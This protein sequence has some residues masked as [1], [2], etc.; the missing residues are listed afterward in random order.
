METKYQKRPIAAISNVSENKSFKKARFSW[1]IKSSSARNLNNGS[2]EDMGTSKL[3]KQHALESHSKMSEQGGS[4]MSCEFQEFSTAK[5]DFDMFNDAVMTMHTCYKGQ[6]S[7]D[8]S[9]SDIDNTQEYTEKNG[10]KQ[11]EGNIADP[12]VRTV[13]NAQ[14]G[15][16]DNELHESHEESEYDNAACLHHDVNSHICMWQKQALGCAIVDNVF[17]RTLEE[18]GLSPDPMVNMLARERL[19]VENESIELAIQ[20]QGLL[21]RNMG[22]REIENIAIEPSNS[23]KSTTFDEEEAPDNKM[24][25]P[26]NHFENNAVEQIHVSCFDSSLNQIHED[27]HLSVRSILN[28]PIDTANKYDHNYDINDDYQGASD[29]EQMPCIEINMNSSSIDSA[30]LPLDN[31]DL[32]RESDNILDLAVST[33]IL[34]QGLGVHKRN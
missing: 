7:E 19:S 13:E 14:R 10:Q 15:N 29:F 12:C 25:T 4:C 6:Y 17:N 27:S 3:T 28:T 20:N 30:T 1:Q 16:Q 24:N 34:W 9:V 31:F 33:A 22:T 2:L 8:Q 5:V 21:A 32:A 26:C 11:A 23:I 18:L